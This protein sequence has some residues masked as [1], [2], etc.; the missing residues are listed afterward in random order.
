MEPM[1]NR[2][3]A[4][5]FRVYAKMSNYLIDRGMQPKFQILDNETCK[6]VMQI[7]IQPQGRQWN[8]AI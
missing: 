4:E 6:R 7:L 2:I 5:I 8:T 1:K 3:D